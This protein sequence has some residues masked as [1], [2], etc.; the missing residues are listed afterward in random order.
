MTQPIV[1]MLTT[2]SKVQTRTRVDVHVDIYV[3]FC[4]VY[5]Y[6]LM[7]LSSILKYFKFDLINNVGMVEFWNLDPARTYI[8]ELYVEDKSSKSKVT[9]REGYPNGMGEV[10]ST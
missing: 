2:T 10:V 8:V 6:W 4:S 7:D 1:H 3:K 5:L 9:R